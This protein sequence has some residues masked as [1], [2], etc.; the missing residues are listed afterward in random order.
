MIDTEHPTK[1]INLSAVNAFGA[2]IQVLRTIYIPKWSVCHDL[3]ESLHH[4]QRMI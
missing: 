2:D 4:F 3:N 1:R